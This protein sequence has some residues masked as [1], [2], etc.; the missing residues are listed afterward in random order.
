MR[1][2]QLLRVLGLPVL[3][4]GCAPRGNPAAG[5]SAGALTAAAAY[6]PIG[7]KWR[8]RVTD[9]SL[10][11]SSVRDRDV[12]ATPVTFD[13]RPGYGLA[14]PG[15][16]CV[17]D[18]ATF[19]PIGT[20]VNGWVAV[21]AKPDTGLFSW[22]LWVG[23]S[24]GT[25]YSYADRLAGIA[26]PPAQS[27]ARVAAL[28]AITVPAGTFQAFRIEFE[29]G[30][31]SEAG[32]TMQLAGPPGFNTRETHWYAPAAKLIVRSEVIRTGENYH[33]AGRETTELLSMP[34]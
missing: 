29:G 27:S 10:F 21:T 24:W 23:K 28:E 6:P 15:F 1:R 8:V 3:A 34:A 12:T 31:G 26:W 9:S 17:L 11:Q 14:S 33:W 2:R 7:T 32:N 22:P 20:L 16:T 18:P 25:T 19:N 13:G 4:A 5:P 30:I